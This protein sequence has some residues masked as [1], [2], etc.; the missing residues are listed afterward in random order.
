MTEANKGRVLVVQKTMRWDA[1]KGELVPKF[2]VSPAQKYGQ[3]EYLLSPTASPFRPDALV[4]EL[5]EK[6]KNFSD[7]DCLLLIGNPVL[8]GMAV[9]IAA[10]YNDGHV[11]V[12]QWSG[13]A[14]EYLPIELRDLF[15][16]CATNGQ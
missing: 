1:G 3:V 9:S 11:R 16:D 12:L 13:R 4:G 5:H 14:S 8:I 10:D 6:L 2:D 7:D 15:S